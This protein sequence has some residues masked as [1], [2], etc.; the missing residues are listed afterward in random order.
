VPFSNSTDRLERSPYAAIGLKCALILR[1]VVVELRGFRA[2]KWSSSSDRQTAQ[3]KKR[4]RSD[5]PNMVTGTRWRDLARRL[6][7]DLADKHER[8]MYGYALIWQVPGIF[9]NMLRG[10]Y[11]AARMPSGSDC[12]LRS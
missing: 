11:L 6:C 3:D 10:R 8:S 9:G 2:G 4:Q 1:G 7:R 12:Q 5:E